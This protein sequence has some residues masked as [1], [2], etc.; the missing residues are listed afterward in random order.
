MKNT[1]ESNSYLVPKITCSDLGYEVSNA[2]KKES[3]MVSKNESVECMVCKVSCQKDTAKTLF[4][5]KLFCP[6]CYSDTNQA[7]EKLI[8][9][10]DI[11]TINTIKIKTWYYNSDK[12]GLYFGDY[13]V[14]I[15]SSWFAVKTTHF[16]YRIREWK[17]DDIDGVLVM[18]Q[19]TST[20][21]I[22]FKSDDLAKKFLGLKGLDYLRVQNSENPICFPFI[23]FKSTVASI[24]F[25]PLTS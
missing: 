17:F 21:S 24:D 9:T 5:G 7:L 4:L 13:S 16:Q 1:R 18:D 23:N 11:L 19:R 8:S 10:W 20:G 12:F 3:I 15:P 6:K 2:A 14:N 22:V 25:E